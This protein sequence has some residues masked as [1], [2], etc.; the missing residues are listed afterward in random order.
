MTIQRSTIARNGRQRFLYGCLVV[1]LLSGCQKQAASSLNE[2]SGQKDLPQIRVDVIAVDRVKW[3]TIVRSH[4]SLVPDE[5]AVIGSRIDG[6][7]SQVDVDL[8]DRVTQ[9][10]TLVTI[11]QAEFQLRVE[12]A[13]AQL[14][15]ARSAVGLRPGDP[16]AQLQPENAPPVLEHKALWNEARG[17]LDR[18]EMLLAKNSIT[19]SEIDQIKAAAAVAE[20][21][22]KSALNSVHEKIAQIGVREAELALAKEQLADTTIVAPF[23]GLIQSRDVSPGT[24]LRTGDAVATL[25]RTDTLRF[26]GTIPE[27]FSLDISVGQS[28]EL[29]IESVATPVKVPVTRISPAVD[30]TSRSLLFEAVVDNSA[31][32]L[33]SGLFAEARIVTDETSTTVAIPHSALVEFAGAEKVWKVVDG[34]AK[35]QQVLTGERR[36]DGIEIL[37]GLQPGDMILSDGREGMV[38]SV[39]PNTGDESLATSSNSAAEDN[40]AEDNAASH[41]DGGNGEH[42]E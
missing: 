2:V 28:V 24:Y 27:R 8:G 35:E 15:Q 18:A 17:N 37:Q 42:A 39:L 4:G 11:G 30:L 21:R 34:V 5:V 29:E 25:V 26:R 10:M 9:G 20:A 14:L 38:A 19:A 7:V 33:R 1:T 40:A 36:A 31:G 13:E 22:F 16:V 6:R 3:P 12:Q 41:A 23:D 32:S